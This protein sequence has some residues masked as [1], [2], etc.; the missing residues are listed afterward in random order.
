MAATISAADMDAAIIGYLPHLDDE[1]K[2]AVLSVVKAFAPPQ[3]HWDDPAFV[4]EMEKRDEDYR[5][6]RVKMHSL[7]EFLAAGR[8]AIEQVRNEPK[9]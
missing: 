1:Q 6:G 2:A 3:D 5:T 8:E 7:D 9:P 4:A